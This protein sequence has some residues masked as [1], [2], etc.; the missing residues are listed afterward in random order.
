MDLRLKLVYTCKL[1]TISGQSIMVARNREYERLLLRLFNT[2]TPHLGGYLSASESSDY[3][4]LY[5][6]IY[7]LTHLLNFTIFKTTFQRRFHLSYE[8]IHTLEVKNP[9]WWSSNNR[10]DHIEPV[11]KASSF[12]KLNHQNCYI[13]ER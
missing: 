6:L 9:G 4:A 1:E 3:M 11:E 7:L 12:Q 8:W 10:N 2:R 13:L 5:K